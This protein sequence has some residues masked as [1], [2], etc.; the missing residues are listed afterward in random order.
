MTIKLKVPVG[1]SDPDVDSI[2]T[3]IDGADDTPNPPASDSTDTSVPPASD[4]TSTEVIEGFNPEEVSTLDQ[5]VVDDVELYVFNNQL[6][7]KTGKPVYNEDEYAELKANSNILDVNL[8]QRYSGIELLDETGTPIEFENTVKGIAKREAFI[9]DMAEKQGRELAIN[10]LFESTPVIKDV[11]QYVKKNGSLEGFKPA[12]DYSKVTLSKDNEDQLT[13]IIIEAELLKGNTLDKAKK[14]ID[15]Y[16][17]DNQLY[18]EAIEAK[19]FIVS[20]KQAQEQARVQSEQ[21]SEAKRRKEI[22]EYYGIDY[23]KNGKEVVVNNEGSLYNKIVS[24]GTVGE[25]VIPEVG[26]KVTTPD[27]TLKTL[28]RRDIFNY[29]ALAVDENG[30]SQA[31]LD[32]IKYMSSTDNRI[33]R[34]LFNLTAGDISALIPQAIANKKIKEVKRFITSAKP[35]TASKGSSTGALKTPV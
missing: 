21:E 5:V 18:E 2:V 33:K 14:Y 6:V 16:K 10:E 4:S 3:P 34:A 25:F 29:I 31:D 20:Q 30:N 13:N 7:D 1:N 23:D 8:I 15:F 24:K 32:E 22:R 19:N 12:T 26:I 35:N 9:K 28:T 27:G 17:A 11:L